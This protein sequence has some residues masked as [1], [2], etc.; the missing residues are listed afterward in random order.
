[1]STEWVDCG[2]A[3][4]ISGIPAHFGSVGGWGGGVVGSGWVGGLVVGVGGGDRGGWVHGGWGCGG[5][6]WGGGCEVALWGW[7]GWCWGYPW[8]YF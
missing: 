4:E 3:H 7:V 5:I 2:G 1:M 6:R 8:S